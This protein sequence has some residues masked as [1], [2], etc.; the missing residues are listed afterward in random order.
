MEL[1]ERVLERYFE[2]VSDLDIKPI[3]HG[4]INFTYAVSD[5]QNQYILQQLNPKVFQFPERIISNMLTVSN[6]LKAQNYPKEVLNIIPNL[7]GNYLTEVDN[8]VWRLTNFIANSICHDQVKSEQQAFAAAKALSEFHQHLFN[9]P[10]QRIAASIDGFLDY[11]KRIDDYH[12]ALQNG[13]QERKDL[14]QNELV[15][16]DAHLHLIERYLTIDFPQRIVHADAKISNFLF[17]END[18]NKVKAI[19]DWDTLIPGNVMCDFGDMIRTYSNLKAE[20]DPDPTENFSLDYYNAV[21]NGFLT[22][23]SDVLTDIELKALDLTAFVVILIQAIRFVTDY[24]NDDVYYHVSHQNQNLDRTI[25]QINLLK[26]I[27]N[28]I[29][30]SA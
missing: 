1:I 5:G 8:D 4:L 30:I 13:N 10:I 16:I 6:H 28:S 27:E 29:K 7:H 26:S 24:L 23:L 19:I 25:N 3:N 22:H 2:R 11:Q 21:K 20:D 18:E 14:A 9:L 17:D 12:K 15:Y